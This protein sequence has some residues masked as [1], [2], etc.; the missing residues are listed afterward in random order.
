MLELE[1]TLQKGFDESIGEFGGFV[2]KESKILHL[3]HS[4]LTLSKWESK[5]EKAFL[6]DAEKS[7][8]ELIDYIRMMIVDDYDEDDLSKLSQANITQ[9]NEYINSKQT[10][11]WFNEKNVRGGGPNSS[12]TITSDLIYYWMV[13]MT[14]PFDP[15]EGWHLNRLI[16]LIK[17][18]DLENQPK[19]N[20]PRR[21]TMANHRSINAAR[22]ARYGTNG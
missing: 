4:L 11:T 22:R 6:G 16:T 8:E 14:I 17:I 3:E 12:R 2:A 5:W 10:A 1:V 19:K 20:Q 21:E 15:C 9:I 18:T 13:A 7:N